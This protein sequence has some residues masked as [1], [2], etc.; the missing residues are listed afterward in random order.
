MEG[1]SE[2]EVLPR[3]NKIA[4]SLFNKKIDLVEVSKE[5]FKSLWDFT[6]IIFLSTYFFVRIEATQ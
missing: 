5:Y 1:L 4:D 6:N 3:H 2:Q